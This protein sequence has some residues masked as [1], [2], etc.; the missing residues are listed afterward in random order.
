MRCRASW[1]Y[2]GKVQLGCSKTKDSPDTWCYVTYP[3]TCP[4][5]TASSADPR[6]IG[7]D[8]FRELRRDKGR[9]CRELQSN[10][11]GAWPSDTL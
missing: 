11:L 10:R 2:D 6:M 5:A 8:P 4:T 1:N 3:K 9:C 7:K